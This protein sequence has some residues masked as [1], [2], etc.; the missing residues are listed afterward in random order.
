[1][2]TAVDLID[3]LA[4]SRLEYD[5]NSAY[6]KAKEENESLNRRKKFWSSIDKVVDDTYSRYPKCLT[7]VTFGV[8]SSPQHP[9]FSYMIGKTEYYIYLH[10][11]DGFKV[12]LRHTEGFIGRSASRHILAKANT[13]DELLPELI[14]KLA[15]AVTSYK[16]KNL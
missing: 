5:R 16:S 6:N 2:K 12:S 7:R 8:P 3:E 14:S 9:Y 1:M 4:T 15:D 11:E 10:T 13:V